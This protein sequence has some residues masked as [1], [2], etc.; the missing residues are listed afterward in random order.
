MKRFK[1]FKFKEDVFASV[2]LVIKEIENWIEK[3]E[4]NMPPF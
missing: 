2:A 4:E 1:E 3:N